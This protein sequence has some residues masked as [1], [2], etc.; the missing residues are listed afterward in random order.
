MRI[1]L[2][3]RRLGAVRLPRAIEASFARVLAVVRRRPPEQAG[4]V[5]SLTPS[6][7]RIH[8]ELNAAIARRRSA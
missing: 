4:F 2:F 3:W 6:A 8:A 1:A 5:S 7:R